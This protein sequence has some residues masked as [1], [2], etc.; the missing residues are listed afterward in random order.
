MDTVTSMQRSK[1]MKRIKSKDTKPEIVLRK[2]LWRIGYRYLKN[3]DEL[4]GKP[5]IV[6][7]TVKNCQVNLCIFVDG[8]YWHG[9][10]YESSEKHEGGKYSCLKEQLEHSNNSAFWLNKIEKNIERDQRVDAE[11]LG[12]G[13]LVLRFW[14]KDVLSH[15]EQCIQTVNET[16]EHVIMENNL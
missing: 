5:D 12:Q 2:A 9:F 16:I 3:V 8:K 6:I 14:D 1:N 7:K 11:L 10:N 15:L 13:W 4:P